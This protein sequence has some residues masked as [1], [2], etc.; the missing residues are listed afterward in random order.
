MEMKKLVA[1]LVLN[2]EVCWVCWGLRPL[3]YRWS[4]FCE[5]RRLTERCV[6]RWRLRI[7]MRTRW[8]VHGFSNTEVYMQGLS[9]GL[10]LAG[11][12]GDAE[13]KL[14]KAWSYA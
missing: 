5:V 14:W 8:N 4:R 2:Y 13:G 10:M 11:Q 3:P 1:F 6:C 12:E 7:R 9:D